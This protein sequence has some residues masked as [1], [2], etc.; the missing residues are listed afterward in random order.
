MDFFDI[1]KELLHVLLLAALGGQ[2][3]DAVL[4]QVF[5]HN[6]VSIVFVCVLVMD[7]GAVLTVAKAVFTLVV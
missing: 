3:P 7:Q 2:V 5:H 6:V 4:S 1:T